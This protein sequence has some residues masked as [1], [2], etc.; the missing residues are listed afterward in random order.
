MALDNEHLQQ[1]IGNTQ[2][3]TDILTPAPVEAMAA[4]LNRADMETIPGT[5]LPPLWHWLYFLAPAH[6]DQLAEDGHAKKGDFLPPVPL[7]RRMWA[8]SLFEF[9]HPLSVGDH[10]QRKSTIKRIDIKKGRSG[11]LAFVCVHHQISDSAGVAISEEHNIVY[12]DN[13]PQTSASS[14]STDGKTAD[15]EAQHSKTITPDPVLLFRY[16]ALTFNGHRIHY[17]RNYTT[18]FEGYPGLIVHGPLLAIFMVELLRERMPEVAMTGFQFRA[19]RPVFDI[20][21]FTVC[22]CQSSEERVEL[23]VQDHDGLLCMQASA[24]VTAQGP[25]SS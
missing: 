23:W 8:G 16:S 19:M 11:E 21:P 24:Q 3:Q 7:P 15:K 17:D 18:R 13:P 4:T 20:N 25:G 2:E 10:V 9:H 1:W 22:L 6:H 5:A 14:N 12:R